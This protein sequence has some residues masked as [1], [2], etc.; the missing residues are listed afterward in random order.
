MGCTV[1][2]SRCVRSKTYLSSC[3]CCLRRWAREGGRPKKTALKHTHTHKTLTQKKN[4][5]CCFVLRNLQKER[6]KGGWLHV[7]FPPSHNTMVRRKR[8]YF[9]I[10]LLVIVIISP[11][12]YQTPFSHS[13]FLG[14]GLKL[15]WGVDFFFFFFLELE[16]FWV[17][18]SSTW[19]SVGR[20]TDLRGDWVDIRRTCC[21][22]DFCLF[23]MASAWCLV[24]KDVWVSRKNS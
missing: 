15:F 18:I 21:T 14:C 11:W 20:C 13:S 12:Y 3:R 10:F 5:F 24:S 22:C 23:F 7:S 9:L 16:T 19:F 17:F 4:F 8:E 2:R 1:L 6:I